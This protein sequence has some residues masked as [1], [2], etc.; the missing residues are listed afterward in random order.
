MKKLLLLLFFALISQFSSASHLAGGEIWYEYAGDTTH[1]YRYNIYVIVYR[2]M[3]GVTMCPGYCPA[4]ICIQS[5]CFP[6]QTITAPLEPFN[7]MPGSDT[8][9]G[10]YPGSIL[11][12]GLSDCVDSS[13]A[14]VYTEMYRFSAQVDLPGMCSD[15]TFTYSVSARNISDNLTSSSYFNIQATLN[16]ASGPNS[17][18][19]FQIPATKAFCIGTTF[20]WSHSCIDAEGDSLFYSLGTPYGGNCSS[21]SPMT[22]S[23]G[24][25]QNLPLTSSTPIYFDSET[26]TIT[27]TPSQVETVTFKIDVTKYR[28]SSGVIQR[29]GSISRD[30]Q[31]PIVSSN[32]CKVPQKSWLSDSS[33][34]STGYAPNLRCG[35]TIINLKVNTPILNS[36]LASDGSDFA[37]INSQGKLVPIIGATTYSSPSGISNIDLK[38]HQPLFYND[39]LY[40]Y[41]R[42]GSDR[43]TLLSYCG[44]EIP[45]GDSLNLVVKNCPT[46]IGLAQNSISHISLYPNPTQGYI[47]LKCN[48]NLTGSFITV[49]DITG[50]PVI[51]KTLIAKQPKLDVSQLSKGIY[52]IRVSNSTW[53]Q[54]IQFEKL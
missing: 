48:R 19:K 11:T 38:L 39:T 26:G 51:S 12:P 25:S 27:F 4:S 37:M 18:P 33:L 32:D 15:Y 8:L 9:K 29:L 30:V 10:S 45:E 36:S 50:R 28:K 13:S 34:T 42:K 20:N 21:S 46:S 16:N 22:F 43:N 41:V 5:S 53:T 54:T 31:V 47:T 44:F 14:M 1:P 3:S 35:D 2:D 24:Y 6:N 40:L 7:L 49:F 17:S 52:N 23:P